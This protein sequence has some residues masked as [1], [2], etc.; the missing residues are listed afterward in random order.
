MLIP[1]FVAK[2]PVIKTGTYSKF[3]FVLTLHE[4][5][6]C[7]RCRNVLNA[8]PDYQPNYCD[9][10]GQKINFSNVKWKKE[11]TIGFT[12]RSGC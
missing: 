12:E 2:R 8:G 6:C 7:P 10:C 4:F 9:K 3:G 11:Q 1:K 5:C